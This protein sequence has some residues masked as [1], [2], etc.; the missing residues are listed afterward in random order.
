MATPAFTHIHCSSRFDRSAESLESDLDDWMS[1]SSLITVTE[2][3]NDN[4]AAKLREKGWSY[5][6]SK[7]NQGQDD[8]GIAWEKAN[9]AQRTGSTKKLSHTTFQRGTRP[10]YVYAATVVL[11]RTDS[12]HKLLA[13][14]SHM[15]AHVEGRGDFATTEDQWQARK[16]AYLDALTGWSTWVKDQER[17]HNTDASLIVADW[18]INLKDD[19]FRALLTDHWGEKYDQAWKHFPTSGGSLGGGPTA[20]DGSPGKGGSDRIIDG[21]LFRD[22]IVT[23]EPDLMDRVASSDHRPYK[24]S[25]RFL[26]KAEKPVKATDGA[27]GQSVTGN[28]GKGHEWWGF[29]DYADDEI[30]DVNRVFS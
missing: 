21:S 26:G 28:T 30:Y 17:K 24:E 7:L 15:P 11:R 19:W 10:V 18:N 20:P 6:N 8:V 13:S 25:F 5:F 22:L 16:K 14:V 4:R 1:Q 23:G 2:V 3:N 9:W 27:Q 12:G 29:G